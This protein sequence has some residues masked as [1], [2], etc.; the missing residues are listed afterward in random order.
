MFNT[1]PNITKTVIMC[2]ALEFFL[3]LQPVC[4]QGFSFTDSKQ[5][6]GRMTDDVASIACGDVNKDGFVDLVLASGEKGTIIQLYLN[7]GNGKFSKT[8]NIFPISPSENPK[9]NFGTVLRDFNRDGLLD[10]ATADAWR[11]VN[12]YRNLGGGRFKRSQ[13]ILVPAVNEVKGIDAADVDHDG[14]DDIVFGGHNGVPDRGDRIFLNDGTGLF[15]DSGQRLGSDVTWDTIFGDMDND[16][17]A[18]FISINR[19][20]V[21]TA[22]IYS[23][24]KRGI[25][26]KK[27]NI[28]TTRTDDSYDV[29]LADFDMD[30]FLDIFIA[31]S[32]NQQYQTTSKLFINNGDYSFELRNKSIGDVNCET[33]GVEVIDVNNDGYTD[34]VLGNYNI[35]N[36]IYINNRKGNL[37]KIQERIPSYGTTDIGAADFNKDGFIDIVVGD[38]VDGCYKVYFNDGKNLI[39]NIAPQPPVNLNTIV[40][41]NTARLKWGNGSDSITPPMGM[42]YNIRVGTKLGANDI[43]SGALAH[44]P[45]HVGHALSYEIRGLKK[46][47]YYWSVQ[48]VDSGFMKS[49]WS[50]NKTFNVTESVGAGP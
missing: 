34:I 19:Y 20:G 40:S 18:D 44:G 41:G 49:K 30:G 25:F 50:S 48:S 2:C 26:S 27:L 32:I 46:G 24:N 35:E 39:K 31:S 7:D 42:T 45:G 5:R 38:S 16:G 36:M 29:A 13:V 47:A 43:V 12:V 23:N 14:D 1:A 22:K 9:W 15:I 28:P 17:Y 21:N 8:D 6:I 4:A 3:Y 33:K 37:A 11:G 10:I